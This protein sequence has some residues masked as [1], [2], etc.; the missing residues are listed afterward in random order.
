MHPKL[1]SEDNDETPYYPTTLEKLNRK[2]RGNEY[3]PSREQ[4]LN[5]Y[6]DRLRQDIQE[7]I[8][9]RKQAPRKNL[10]IREKKALHRLSRNTDIVIKPADKGGATVILNTEDYLKEAERQLTNSQYYKKVETDLTKDH[11]QLINQCLDNLVRQG[12]LQENTSALLRVTKSRTPI[13]Y[14]LPKIHKPNNPR[15]PVVSSVNSH[16]E[17]ISAYVDEFLRPLAEKLP[18]YI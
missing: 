1:K 16:T 7:H 4:Y 15:R 18:S 2:K 12:E 8:S 3:R 6:I 5:S 13:F 9:N 10:N 17:K 14:L 11:E